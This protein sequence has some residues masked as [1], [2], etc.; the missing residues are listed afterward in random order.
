MINTMHELIS[1]LPPLVAGGLFGLLFFGGLWLTVNYGMS[2]SYPALWFFISML[3]RT[4]IV[5]TGFY[6]VTAGQ[7]GRLLACLTGFIVSR[8][9][10]TRILKA[11]GRELPARKEWL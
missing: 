4:G 11:S 3:L 7:F 6:F 1:L 9:I 10:I 5:L 2:S 8:L